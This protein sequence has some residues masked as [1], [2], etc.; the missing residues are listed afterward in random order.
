MSERRTPEGQKHSFEQPR[1]LL[2]GHHLLGHLDGDVHVD[3]RRDE[4]REHAKPRVEARVEVEEV[5]GDNHEDGHHLVRGRRWVGPRGGG[6]H[7]QRR[8]R[9]HTSESNREWGSAS[10]RG[11]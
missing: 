5:D 8:R 9:Y 2:G 1:L 3:P 11:Y 4:H 7:E 6:A 10:K